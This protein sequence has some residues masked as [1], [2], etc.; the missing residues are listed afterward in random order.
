M[1]D[2]L[3]A[4]STARPCRCLIWFCSDVCLLFVAYA[5]L[6]TIK[7][8]LVCQLRADGCYYLDCLSLLDVLEKNYTFLELK[9]VVILNKF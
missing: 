1:W 9:C 7:Y 8:V 4:H 5:I 6:V 2:L 3:P